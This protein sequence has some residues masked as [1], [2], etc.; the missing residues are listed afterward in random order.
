MPTNRTTHVTAADA[1][2]NVAALTD[3]K[4]H[5]TLVEAMALLRPRAPEARPGSLEGELLARRGAPHDPE[6]TAAKERAV[7]VGQAG[8]DR[9]ADRHLGDV[10]RHDD[11][12]ALLQL[13]SAEH[14]GIGRIA[15]L[16]RNELEDVCRHVQHA[17]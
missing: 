15:L 13:V 8:Q 10:A 6:E 14:R 3:H 7:V 9:L 5:A 2:G 1:H 12:L 4:D 17:G 16:F 11:V